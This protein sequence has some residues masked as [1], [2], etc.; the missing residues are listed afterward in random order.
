MLI[1]S[2]LRRVSK[3]LKIL[4]SLPI[5]VSTAEE[6]SFFSRRRLKT[7]LRR[8]MV[9]ERLNW[10]ALLHIH[11]NTNLNAENATDRHAEKKEREKL[12]FV[13]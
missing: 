7:W 12:D 8:K 10:L 11:R 3:F 1:L 6:V 2:T 5:S 4:A 13:L 9:Q